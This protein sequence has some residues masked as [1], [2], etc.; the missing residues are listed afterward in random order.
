VHNA[1]ANPRIESSGLIVI[2]WITSDRGKP[3]A[4]AISGLSLTLAGVDVTG[5]Y[6]GRATRC[7]SGDLAPRGRAAGSRRLLFEADLDLPA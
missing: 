2:S 5:S 3:R 6:R 1:S 7:A 4:E